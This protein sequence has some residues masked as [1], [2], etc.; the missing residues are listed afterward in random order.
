MV[1]SFRTAI[2][3]LTFLALFCYSF[4]QATPAIKIGKTTISKE[5]IDSLAILLGQQ[6][7]PGQKLTGQ[8]HNILK[9]AV[10]GNLIGH[11]LLNLESNV[12]N[13]IVSKSELDSIF[14]MF[15]ANFKND[16]DFKTAIKNV[17]D[18][19][20]S[21]KKKLKKQIRIE[22]LLYKYLTPLKKPDKK[23]I[24]QFFEDNKSDI[25]VNDSLRASQIV[26]QLPAGTSITSAGEARQKLEEI[27]AQLMLETSIEFLVEKFSQIAYSLSQSPEAKKG[28]DLGRFK[29]TDFLAEFQKAIKGLNVGDLSEIFRT[30]I[31]WHLVLVTEKNDGNPNNYRLQIIQALI[32]KQNMENQ[33]KLE[34]YLQK[35]VKKYKVTYLDTSYRGKISDNLN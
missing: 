15:K 12:T 21:L 8:Q 29:A 4:T 1:F 11:E 19:E 26:I 18:T 20:E 3:S 17:G 25:P 24:S 10:A 13:I 9:K 32:M 23:A 22:K 27:K 7:L 2:P 33:E 16:Q 30:P 6:Q 35:L 34:L 31:G 28:G 14:D 5:R